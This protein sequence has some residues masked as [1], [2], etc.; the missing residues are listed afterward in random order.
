[1][2]PNN[3]PVSKDESQSNEQFGTLT[4]HSRQKPAESRHNRRQNLEA[5]R[6]QES[7]LWVGVS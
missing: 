3:K 2:D 4:K 7:G 5:K 6:D 1:M